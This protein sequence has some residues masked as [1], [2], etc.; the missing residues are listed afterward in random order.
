MSLLAIICQGAARREATK[1]SKKKIVFTSL[2][3]YIFLNFGIELFELKKPVW[4][5]LNPL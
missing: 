4:A 2:K 1:Q 3:I 5:Q